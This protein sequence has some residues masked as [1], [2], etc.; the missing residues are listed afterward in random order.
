MEEL[1]IFLFQKLLRNKIFDAMSDFQNLK[2]LFIHLVGAENINL[3]DRY[4]I[5]YSQM[6]LIERDMKT[7]Q[8]LVDRNIYKDFK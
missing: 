6:E 2:E 5:V 8:Q 4:G 7:L 3:L 1:R